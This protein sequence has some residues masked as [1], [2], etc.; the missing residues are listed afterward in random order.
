ME[1]EEGIRE[2]FLEE[3]TPV[4]G[5]TFQ[6]EHEQGTEAWKRNAA[7]PHPPETLHPIVLDG[8]NFI[9]C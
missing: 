7:W 1:E 5:G 4:G 8:P 3:V 9:P 6:S 2:G